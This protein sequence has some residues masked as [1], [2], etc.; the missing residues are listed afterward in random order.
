MKKIITFSAALVLGVCAFGATRNVRTANADVASDLQTLLTSYNDGGYTKKTQMYL[1]D[2]CVTEMAAYFH[3]GANTLKRATYYNADETA[4]L[5]GN[6]DG[7][8]KGIGEANGINSGYRNKGEGV[9]HFAYV[10]TTP[11]EAN[12]FVEEKTEADWTAIGQTVGGYYQT[13]SSLAASI[14]VSDWVYSDGAFIHDIANL[15]VTDG[16]YDDQIL[17]KFQYFAAPMMLQN[18]YF[19]WHTIRVVEGA[20]FLSIRLYT[21]AADG[22]TKSTLVGTDEALVSEARIYKGIHCNPEVEWTLAGDFTDKLNLDADLYKPEQYSLTKTVS[23]GD[24]FVITDGTT[25]RGYSY[26]ET[27]A[28]SWFENEGGQ[29]KSKVDG[30]IT[31]YWK[32]VK[33]LSSSTMWIAVDNDATANLT[34]N[35]TSSWDIS[36]ASAK[37]VAWVWG[38][39][40]S[41]GK[42]GTW[43][44]IT[45]NSGTGF[46]DEFSLTLN[47]TATGMQIVRLNPTITEPT[48][49][50]DWGSTNNIALVAGTLS[51]NITWK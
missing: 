50:G 42:T 16:E 1:T 12:F 22:A 27:G 35:T 31:I 17:K 51:Y 30:T 47:V 28:Q 9:E 15:H 25:N 48:W 21:T 23:V 8:F 36:A 44:E 20:S 37:F 2:T 43:V 5:M 45:K 40:Y 11:T 26:I 13:L 41:E 7:T 33:D 19:S 4:L 29:I 10:D 3:A 39:S 49:E 14:N 38:G 32:P 34:I 6:Y 46:A 18:A 24:K